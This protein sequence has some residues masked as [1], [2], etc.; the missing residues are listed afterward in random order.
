M[1][2]GQ[3][4]DIDILINSY[5]AISLGTMRVN[6]ALLYTFQYGA[7]ISIHSVFIRP[8]HQMIFSHNNRPTCHID[9]VYR[10]V[11]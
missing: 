2:N 7:C 5:D 1:M 11:A 8:I 9:T 10:L 6:H 3:C 4:N